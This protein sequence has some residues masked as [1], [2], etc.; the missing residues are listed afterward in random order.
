MSDETEKISA[1]VAAISGELRDAL[2]MMASVLRNYGYFGGASLREMISRRIDEIGPDE[3]SI[4]V[5]GS[6]DELTKIAALQ[7][8]RER[9]LG[10]GGTI[11]RAEKLHRGEN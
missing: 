3:G 6:P 2:S 4:H 5:A 7:Q 8:L 9:L 10:S 1:E 11:E